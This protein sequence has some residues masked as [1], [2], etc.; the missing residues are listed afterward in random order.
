LEEIFQLHIAAMPS[1]KIIAVGLAQRADAG[2]AVLATNLAV[3]I[4]TTIIQARV[5]I[6]IPHVDVS[7]WLPASDRRGH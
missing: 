7:L 2:I 5:T 6:P 4:S 1:R 3:A